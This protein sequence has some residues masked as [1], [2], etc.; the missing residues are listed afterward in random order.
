[1]LENLRLPIIYLTTSIA[2]CK[3]I[4]SKD[5]YHPFL[6]KHIPLPLNQN[7]CHYL[8]PFACSSFSFSLLE[9][10]F[11]RVL[12]ELSLLGPEIDKINKLCKVNNE[13]PIS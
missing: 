11:Q 12:V 6:Y 9:F 8:F 4:K 1:M 3:L 10:H 2:A 13:E 5:F 7:L